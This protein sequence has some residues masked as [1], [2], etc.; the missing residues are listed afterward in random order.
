MK[1]LILSSIFSFNIFAGLIEGT[2]LPEVI[3]SGENGTLDG[4]PW[5]SSSFKTPVNVFFYVDPDERDANE[6][7]SEVLS[8]KKYPKNKVTYYGAINYDATPLPNFILK[9][10][11]KQKQKKYPD[12][13]Y[14]NDYDKTLVKKWNL[15]DDSNTLTILN[16][17]SK[18]LFSKFGALTDE[19]IEKVVKLIE[20]KIK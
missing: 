18:V 19:E 6:K 11:I 4:K 17:D 16:K 14:L 15:K 12:T 3:L 9:N 10:L 13:I 20:G 5:T 1:V 7:I 2:V 8:A